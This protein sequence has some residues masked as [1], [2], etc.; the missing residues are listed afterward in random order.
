MLPTPPAAPGSPP[1][2]EPTRRRSHP[3][4]CS[5]LPPPLLH[6]VLR[7]GDAEQ[8]EAALRT[9]ATDETLRLL[10][11][12]APRLPHRP[13]VAGLVDAG[14]RRAVSDAQNGT[15]LP[16]VLV[17]AEGA[18]PTG[19]P[20]VDEAYEHLGTSHAFLDVTLARASLDDEGQALD[21][22]VH[23]DVGYDNAFWDG[24][25]MVFGDGDGRLFGR[26]TAALDV[27]AHELGHG[28]TADEAGLVYAGEPG[29]LNEHVSDVLGVTTAQWAAG[30]DDPATAAW[31]VGAALLLPAVQGRALRDMA[32]PGTAYDDPVLG[33]DPQVGHVRDFVVTTADNG[34]VHL[35]SGIPN[36]AFVVACRG[37]G[38][39]SWG[40]VGAVWYDALRDAA[41]GPRTRFAGFAAATLRAAG[42]RGVEVA[43]AVRA[44]W[45][46]V[47]VVPAAG[48]G[49]PVAAGALP[50]GRVPGART[51]SR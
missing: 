8:R 9:L 51:L 17:R 33:R 11:A 47:G 2:S 23:F 30:A 38:A 29:A 6:E 14:P 13:R 28:V 39:P 42:L 46:A 22:T 35:N 1:P 24:E 31:T 27:V 19:D 48:V 21:A 40:P 10:R 16:G 44:G 25:R 4:A 7:R 12:T 26:F 43:D 34:G 20:A 49:T 5:V 45:D 18:P 36:R 3:A 32:A 15:A 41:V 37:L 50:G